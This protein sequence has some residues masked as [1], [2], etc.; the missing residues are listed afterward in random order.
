MKGESMCYGKR[1]R[2]LMETRKR[3]GI[4]ERERERRLRV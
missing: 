2:K 3:K 1:E 4:H